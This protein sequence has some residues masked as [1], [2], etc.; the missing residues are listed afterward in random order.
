MLDVTN[1]RHES[2]VVAV[3]K[4]VHKT[5]SPDKVT[6]MYDAVRKEV[7]E[8]IIR[9]VVVSSN[10]LNGTVFE[11]QPNYSIHSIM[12]VFRF[13]LNGKE[14]VFRET[15]PIEA[16]PVTLDSLG[17]KLKAYFV[18]QLSRELTREVMSFTS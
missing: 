5:I 11:M 15:E 8:D 2:K 9:K 4:E 1:V 7:E 17:M 3:T 12:R 16:V 10:S 6:E 13:V 18:E 14:F